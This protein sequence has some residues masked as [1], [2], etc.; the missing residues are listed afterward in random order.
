MRSDAALHRTVLHL[1]GPAVADADARPGPR[2]LE[3]FGGRP[4]TMEVYKYMWDRLRM[5]RLEYKVQ[6]YFSGAAPVTATLVESYERM[7][8][9]HLT[10]DMELQGVVTRN[11]DRAEMEAKGAKVELPEGGG[12]LLHV[13][14]EG[15]RFP[16][17][18]CREVC[19]LMPAIC[20][21]PAV[22]RGA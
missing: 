8:R 22:F 21:F 14:Q 5:V 6:G 7:A 15:G 17:S 4:Y 10:M 1:T 9:F 20:R 16:V 3:A 2:L 18:F 13:V 19:L 11:R 12:V